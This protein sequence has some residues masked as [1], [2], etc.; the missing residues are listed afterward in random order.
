MRPGESGGNLV[1]GDIVYQDFGVPA[2]GGFIEISVP[3]ITTAMKTALWTIYLAGGTCNV[4]LTDD[5]TTYECLMQ[6][7]KITPRTSRC[8]EIH[9]SPYSVELSFRVLSEV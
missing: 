7:P 1:G 9:D 4:H 3:F 2:N 5:N 8:S 6:T